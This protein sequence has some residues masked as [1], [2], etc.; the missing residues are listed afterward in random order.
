MKQKIIISL[1]FIISFI[2]IVN[3]V[4]AYTTIPDSKV[5]VAINM[6]ENSGSIAKDSINF[7]RFNLTLS[8]DA[9]WTTGVNGSAINTSCNGQAVSA[10]YNDTGTNFNTTNAT[11][12]LWIKLNSPA[13]ICHDNRVLFQVANNM[14]GY[15]RYIDLDWEN[16]P[17]QKAVLYGP[18]GLMNDGVSNAFVVGKWYSFLA[19]YNATD[20]KTYYTIKN[21]TGGIWTSATSATANTADTGGLTNTI[22][23]GITGRGDY[24]ADMF[25]LINDTINQTQYDELFNNG[26]GKPYT[27][28]LPNSINISLISPVN[29]TF[30]VSNTPL[31]SGNIT[32]IVGS[33]N[34]SLIVNNTNV[35]VVSNKSSISIFNITSSTIT[36]FNTPL[37]WYFWGIDLSNSTNTFNSSS[38]FIA[39]L[40]STTQTSSSSCVLSFGL[41][42][43]RPNNCQG[44]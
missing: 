32:S 34:I 11:I 37:M 7:G 17:S 1:I 2:I 20:R 24:V 6:D 8:G 31:F 28:T 27:Q 21:Q 25:V 30:S 4:I 14:N 33:W 12:H 35:G 42:S 13:G 36:V 5:L 26:N 38:S 39:V 3:S 10:N 43:F 16:N 9:S 40:N 23:I 29:N 18:G 15:K 44:G 41:Y 22:N 19:I